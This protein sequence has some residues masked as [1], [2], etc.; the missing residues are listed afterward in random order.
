MAVGYSLLFA[1]LLS[2]APQAPSRTPAATAIIRGRV[3]A[4]DTGTPVRSVRVVLT[5]LPTVDAAGVPILS[6]NLQIRDAVTG[7]SGTYEFAG[8][9]P[10]RYEIP[11]SYT[12]LTL[13]TI[14]R[15]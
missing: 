8:L 4:A 6:V 13:P 3:V 11:V 10:G 14:L 15:V 2:A 9:E 5:Q 1:L 12:H 7:R